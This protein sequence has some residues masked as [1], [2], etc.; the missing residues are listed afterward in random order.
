MDTR[1]IENKD[2]QSISRRRFLKL[3]AAVCA[4]AATPPMLIGCSKTVNYP[5]NDCLAEFGSVSAVAEKKVF[6]TAYLGPIK[7]KNRLI[8]SAT[9]LMAADDFGRPTSKLLDLYSELGEGGVGT[10][11]TG[12]EDGGLMVDNTTF[13]DA[14][15]DAYRKVP[16]VIHQYGAAAIQQI[17]HKGSQI[18]GLSDESLYS[19]NRLS[20][21]EIEQL[22]QQFVKNID[23]SRQMG[24]DGAQLHGAHGY[25]LSEF[26]SPAQNRRT[27]KW[28]GSTGNRFRFIGEIIKR[29]KQKHSDFPIFIKI[30]G[31]D[32]QKNGMREPEAVKIAKLLEKAGCDGIEVSCGVGRDGFS[33]VRT[34]ELPI[35]AILELTPYREKSSVAKFFISMGARY[36]LKSYTPLYN[37]N[38]CAASEIKKNVSIP[39]MVVGGIRTLQ[40]MQTIVVNNLADFVSMGRPF[41]IEPGIVNSLKHKSQTESACIDCGY[42]LLSATIKD[43]RC[44]YGEIS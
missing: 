30:N 31:Y 26:L 34:P 2:G 27:D 3:S 12:M 42:C 23:R 38:V 28:G 37:Y 9:S 44:F 33:I 22:I 15:M 35:D 32:F 20:G 18:K 1:L 16:Q 8:R 40:D 13:R 41:I 14:D 43:V 21:L 5:S 39:V 7:I 19:L 10:I 11:I 29:S 4:V 25:L 17:S 24:F 36:K 6:E